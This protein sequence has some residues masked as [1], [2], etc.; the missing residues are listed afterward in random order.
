MMECIIRVFAPNTIE[1][2]SAFLTPT[3]R[4]QLEH[5]LAT[6]QSNA[7]KVIWDRTKWTL[8]VAEVE[9]PLQ[10]CKLICKY[11]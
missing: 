10:I 2:N 11:I 4:R 5:Q 3:D 7:I 9:I 8:G 1:I 6:S